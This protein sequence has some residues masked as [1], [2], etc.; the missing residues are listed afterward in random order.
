[1]SSETVLY[2]LTE[3]SKFMM[4]FVIVTKEDNVIVIDGGRAED[5]P[6]LKEY[7][8]GRHISAWILTHAHGDHIGGFVSE[9]KRNG[10]ADYDIGCVY[11]NFPPYN[12]LMEKTD[13][14]D[15]NYF[16]AELSGILPDFLEIEPMLEGRA[17]IARQGDGW[18]K[19]VSNPLLPMASHY[20][21]ESWLAVPAIPLPWWTPATCMP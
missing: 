9:M 10:G 20:R 16:R 14:P 4:S 2:Q 1:M 21:R 18:Q 13:V 8:A 6:L 5:M 15:L 7:V 17:H 11:Y 3:T 19:R 12:E